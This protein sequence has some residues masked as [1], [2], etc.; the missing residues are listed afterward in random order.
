MYKQL[1]FKSLKRAYQ[2]SNKIHKIYGYNPTVYNVK[3][4]KTKKS[5]YVVIKPYGLK[6]L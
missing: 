3:N 4:P 1:K 2:E 5:W 6:K